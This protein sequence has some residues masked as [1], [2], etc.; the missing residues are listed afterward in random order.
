MR[1]GQATLVGIPIILYFCR[2]F[3]VMTY[4]ARQ[5]ADYLAGTIEGDETVLVSNVSKIEEGIPGTLT[6][7]ANPKYAPFIYE[8][9]ASVVLVN[10]D[11]V[12]EQPLS[13]TLIRVDNAYACLAKLLELVSSS[14]KKKSGIDPRAAIDPTA[15]IGENA[16]IG[17]FSVVGAGTVIGKDAQIYPQVYIGDN[18]TVGDNCLFYPGVKLL[19]DCVVGN[20]CILQAGAVIGGD[21]FGFVPQQTGSYEKIAQIGNVILEDNVEIG[22][23][24]TIDRATMGST[25]IRKGVKLDNLIQVGHNVEIG[26]DTVAAAQ[27]GFAG[28]TKIG[29]HCMFG[30]QVGLVGHLKIADGVQIGAQSGVPNSINDASTPYMGSPAFPAKHYAR[31]YAVFKKLPELY[32]E[33]SIMRKEI[34]ALKVMK[35]K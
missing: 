16:Y 12:P 6:F 22:A 29:Q 33:I 20:N 21:G 28:S 7:L 25:I 9:K 24:T 10:R 5:I 35:N 11:F 26:E 4:T 1:F 2:N 17:C 14:K 34:D 32:P 8:T 30:G 18:V 27:C 3:Q 15:S 19:D 31:A 23:N 13:T